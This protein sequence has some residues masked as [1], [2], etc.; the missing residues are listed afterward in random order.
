MN[1][2][3]TT[4][5]E[6]ET[7][8]PIHYLVSYKDKNIK[9]IIADYK[10]ENGRYNK[11]LLD[12]LIDICIYSILH[13]PNT[14]ILFTS[15]PSTMYHKKEKNVDSMNNLLK[16]ASIYI[17]DYFNIKS[18]NGCIYFRD[19]FTIDINYLK[20]NGARHIKNNRKSRL[21]NSDRYCIKNRFKKYLYN[22][23]I[24][25]IDDI[26]TTGGTLSSCQKSLKNFSSDL[27]IELFSIAH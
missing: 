20:N 18:H 24:V 15:P 14:D 17:N 21:S 27:D 23:K 6:H 26:S 2:N 1:K 5:N 25:I 9:E 10:F 16:L 13:N 8:L 7:I 4:T 22:A 11:L 19:L 3:I 12:I